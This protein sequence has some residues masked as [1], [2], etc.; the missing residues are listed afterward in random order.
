M[1]GHQA[2]FQAYHLLGVSLQLSDGGS[3]IV[4]EEVDF[5][6]KSFQRSGG[7]WFGLLVPIPRDDF[8]VEKWFGAVG[9]LERSRSLNVELEK[10]PEVAPFLRVFQEVFYE[11]RFAAAFGYQKDFSLKGC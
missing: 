6:G 3:A 11:I 4:I 1:Y 9:L 10:Y 7:G 8:F 2:E 5:F